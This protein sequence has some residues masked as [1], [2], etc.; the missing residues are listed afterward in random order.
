MD[1]ARLT[2]LLGSL[3]VQHPFFKPLHRKGY[4]AEIEMLELLQGVRI[5]QE[6]VPL[7]IHI[8]CHLDGLLKGWSFICIVALHVEAITPTGDFLM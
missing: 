7:A 5:C 1:S 4:C 2:F 6:E 3:Q 8:G